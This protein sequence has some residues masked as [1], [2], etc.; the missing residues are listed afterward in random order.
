[1]EINK[2]SIGDILTLLVIISSLCGYFFKKTSKAIVVSKNQFKVVDFIENCEL[3][4]NNVVL[5]SNLYYTR[6]LIFFQSPTDIT[7]AHVIEPFQISCTDNNCKWLQI[8]LIQNKSNFKPTIKIIENKLTITDAIIKKEDLLEIE[9]FYE[10]NAPNLYYTNRILNV[11]NHVKIFKAHD[12]KSS[13]IHVFRTGVLVIL[14]AFLSSLTFNDL[15]DNFQKK[16]DYVFEYEYMGN[17]IKD[18]SK[19]KSDDKI[20]TL[21]LKMNK[22]KFIK[23][24]DLDT[25]FVINFR[26][27]YPKDYADSFFKYPE[28]HSIFY[29]YDTYVSY[30]KPP[31]SRADSIFNILRKSSNIEYDIFYDIDS[32]TKFKIVNTKYS[33]SLN[34]WVY[35]LLFL[36]FTIFTIVLFIGFL[37][38][39]RD[40]LLF[41]PIKSLIKDVI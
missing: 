32:N 13:L 23:I 2:I 41:F 39:L 25:T 10:A 38:N 26:K 16:D 33:F 31:S 19:N 17:V 4:F 30:I 5:N 37:I 1:M 18:L 27:N 12:V 28:R 6:I 11:N 20:D 35:L 3:K 36:I 29:N 24:Q 8:R 22:S 40:Y 14:F 21:Y 34:I 7:A 15:V 9:F